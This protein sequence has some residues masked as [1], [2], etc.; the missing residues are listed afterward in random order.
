MAE[1]LIVVDRR[2]D[3]KSFYPTENV[4]TFQEYLTEQRGALPKGTRILN[5]CRDYRY[6][7]NGYY[8][9]LL[10]EARGHR[11]MPTV[12]TLNDLGRKAIY[13]PRI[14]ELA[15]AL[16]SF[17]G[18]AAPDNAT[19]VEMAFCFG[20]D[21]VQ[22]ESGQSPFSSLAR[23]LFEQFACPILRVTFVASTASESKRTA[24]GDLN[25]TIESVAAGRLHKLT[26]AEEDQFA[27]AL[28]HFSRQVWRKPRAQRSSRFDLAILV[29]EQEAMPPSDARALKRFVKAGRGV[30]LDVE[31]ISKA[32]Y[33]R[34]AEFDGLFIRETTG[35]DNHTYRFAKRAEAEGLVVIDDAESILRC[36]NKVYLADLL[37]KNRVP[38]PATRII[39]RDR[40]AEL[41]AVGD[42]LGYPLVL[43]IP[44][45]S[46]SRGVVKVSNI[47]ELQREAAALFK[48]SA[49]L[50]VQEFMFTDYDWRIGVLAGEPLFACQY[51]MSQGHWQIYQHGAG[52]DV[53]SGDS[54][55]VSVQEAPKAVVQAAVKAAGLIGQ[56]LYGVDVKQKGNQA[57]VI[58]VNDNPNVDSGVEDEFLGDELY[59]QIMREFVRRM[60]RRGR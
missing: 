28:D 22:A 25:W 32:D 2:Q 41:A 39:S 43:K 9:S 54:R 30:G 4:I 46:F 33:G 10:A 16:K 53:G 15:P 38:A 42:A 58:E 37:Q 50:L 12:R 59:Q 60:E 45:G 26:D 13:G 48:R 27:R 1:L 29:N 20:T 19:R 52:G 55:T 35:I 47:D 6:L 5:L 24:A 14:Q 44:D 8:C 11:V 7:S 23:Q 49:L 31:L 17:S 36:T 51:F 56:S 34:L 21:A 18:Q 57:F 3:W 40:K